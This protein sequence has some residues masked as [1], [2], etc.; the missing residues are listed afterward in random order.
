MGRVLNNRHRDSLLLFLLKKNCEGNHN[1]TVLI[2]ESDVLNPRGSLWATHWPPP[3]NA[4]LRGQTKTKDSSIVNR[5]VIVKEYNQNVL[6]QLSLKQI[7]G[8]GVIHLTLIRHYWSVSATYSLPQANWAKSSI[9][10][11]CTNQI[12]WSRTLS[13]WGIR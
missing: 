4:I 13:W 5:K 2:N 11:L 10:I 6:T 1:F 8:G 7:L 12:R 9:N 3:E